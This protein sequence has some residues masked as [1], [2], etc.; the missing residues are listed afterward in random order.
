M[1]KIAFI[2]LGNMGGPMA[3]NLVR[4]GFSVAG[5]DRSDAACQAAAELGV[6][7]AVDA[8]EGAQDADMILTMLPV[9]ADVLAVWSQLAPLAK[10]G[11]LFIDSSTIDVEQSRAAHELARAAG[12]S[13]VDAPVSGG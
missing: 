3:A 2:G 1:T 10:R 8:V 12:C 7:I 4:G 9:G 13:S 11:A 5:Y 6:A